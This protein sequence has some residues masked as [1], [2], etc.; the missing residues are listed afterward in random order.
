MIFS[1]FLFYNL[2]VTTMGEGKGGGGVEPLAALTMFLSFPQISENYRMRFLL[3]ED[4]IK[5]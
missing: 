5:A 1:L 2:I 3:S 4:I